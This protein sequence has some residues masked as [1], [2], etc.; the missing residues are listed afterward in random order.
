[1]AARLR[2]RGSRRREG[3]MGMIE[4]AVMAAAVV[5]ALGFVVVGG[6]H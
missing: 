6:A 4:L 2:H 1:L 3:L 5:L